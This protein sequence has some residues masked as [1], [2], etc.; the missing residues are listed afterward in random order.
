M[1]NARP[2]SANAALKSMA[3][4]LQMKFL[5]SA[6]VFGFCLHGATSA[7][8]DGH[9]E[10]AVHRQGSFSQ[11]AQHAERSKSRSFR[12]EELVVG[13]T[14]KDDSATP[15]LCPEDTHRR[16]GVCIDGVPVF[17]LKPSEGEQLHRLMDG[18]EGGA[19]LAE[20][21][22]QRLQQKAK[23]ACY[24][25]GKTILGGE[26]AGQ[27]S[28][29]AASVE[30]CQT[31][32]YARSE[33]KFFSF[34]TDG[35]GWCG[36]K[37]SDAEVGDDSAYVSGPRSCNSMKQEMW[38][39]VLNGF[40]K[41]TGEKAFGT[42]KDCHTF[43]GGLAEPA[44]CTMTG[45]P[46]EGGVPFVV[47]QASIMELE[48]I[49]KKQ[50]R[51]I[52]SI[53]RD[54]E[55]FATTHPDVPPPASQTKGL[56]RE[57]AVVRGNI[58]FAFEKTNLTTGEVVLLNEETRSAYNDSNVRAAL[59]SALS[60]AAGISP[61]TGLI[62]EL[63]EL[64]MS[65]G[66]KYIMMSYEIRPQLNASAR[67]MQN[68]LSS[69]NL[70]NMDSL[71]TRAL[72]DM[73]VLYGIEVLNSLS[74]ETNVSLVKDTPQDYQC[75]T[76]YAK[77]RASQLAANASND[78]DSN[79][80]INVLAN[81]SNGPKVEK[82][83]HLKRIDSR[84]NLE[85]GPARKPRQGGLGI[86]VYVIDTGI[87]FLHKEFQGH[88]VPTFETHNGYVR[89]C[90]LHHVDCAADSHGHGTAVASLIG[91][92]MYGV[93]TGAILHSAKAIGSGGVGNLSNVIKAI[94]WIMQHAQHPAVMSMSLT[95]EGRSNALD[96]ALKKAIGESN[97][98][99]IV[100]AGD[101]GQQSACNFA[102]AYVDEAITVAATS[103]EDRLPVFANSGG[104]VDM[105]A[106]GEEIEAADISDDTIGCRRFSSSG[107]SAALVAGTAA[108]ILSDNRGA[109][110]GQVER[111][112]LSD[113]TT[114]FNPPV[115]RML[116]IGKPGPGREAPGTLQTHNIP[117]YPYDVR[118]W[119]TEV[120]GHDMV[121]KS[122]QLQSPIDLPD[123]DRGL[124]KTFYRE[125]LQADWGPSSVE[126]LHTG[127]SI[128]MN[129]K[130]DM[131]NLTTVFG[132]ERTDYGVETLQF[133]LKSC[134]FHVAS[135]HELH[136]D[137]QAME[138]SCLHTREIKSRCGKEVS[139][140]L[141]IQP[142]M[143]RRG[144]GS[145]TRCHDK[146]G[147][148]HRYSSR[149]R[150]QC[151]TACLS[152][153]D[154]TVFE[155]GGG[156]GSACY[157]YSTCKRVRNRLPDFQYLTYERCEKE[158]SVTEH[159]MLS[160][161]FQVHEF[162]NP[163]LKNFIDEL[164]IKKSVPGKTAPVVRNGKVMFVS[165][166]KASPEGLD[167]KKF[168]Q[169][170]YS[171]RYY[172][173]KGS[174]TM[175]PCTEG[176][177]TYV[178]ADPLPMSQEQLDKMANAIDAG[179]ANFRPPQPLGDRCVTD[180]SGYCHN[181]PI[182]KFD[183]SKIERLS[184]IAAKPLNEVVQRYFLKGLPYN[185][186]KEA[187]RNR[188]KTSIEGTVATMFK[189]GKNDATVEVTL[190]VHESGRRRRAQ[191]PEGVLRNETNFTDRDDEDDD[192]A[193]R[194]ITGA[195]A[196]AGMSTGVLKKLRIT[197]AWPGA[198]KA[199][200]RLPQ[201]IDADNREA[202]GTNVEV[203]DDDAS[204]ADIDGPAKTR[205]GD[206]TDGDDEVDGTEVETVVV[207]TDQAGVEPRE[208]H[209]KLKNVEAVK[210]FLDKVVANIMKEVPALMKFD[211]S[212][213]GNTV[214]VFDDAT[215]VTQKKAAPPDPFSC[216][217]KRGMDVTDWS[218][219]KKKWCCEK[220]EMGCEAYKNELNAG[221]LARMAARK[222]KFGIDQEGDD[223]ELPL[224]AWTRDFGNHSCQCVGIA[225][226]SGTTSAS[227][228]FGTTKKLV[229]YPMDVGSSCHAWD[230][231][232]M[233]GACTEDD[234]DPSIGNG[235]CAQPWC[236]V[237]PCHCDL[238]SLPQKATYFPGVTF[239]GKQL[240]YSYATCG[241]NDYYGG[242]QLYAC[243]NQKT[244]AE[245]E[246]QEE[247]KW[248]FTQKQCLGAEQFKECQ[249]PATSYQ[250]NG[251]EECQC[252]GFRELPGTT[253]FLLGSEDVEYPASDGAICSAWDN[254]H[255][256]GGC[257]EEDSNKL[258]PGFGHGWC[259]A[260]WCFVDPC[261]CDFPW[262]ATSNSSYLPQA[263]FQG[264][265]MAL[266]YAT[267]ADDQSTPTSEQSR[268]I[269]RNL[270]T[271]K[272]CDRRGRGHCVWTPAGCVNKDSIELCRD[273]YV[274]MGWTTTTTTSA[275]ALLTGH[276]SC[277]CVGIIG[278]S[279]ETQAMLGK[280]IVSYP[281][282]VGSSCQAWDDGRFTG[283]CAN[284][285]DEPGQGNG[286]CQ[287]SWCYVNPCDCNLPMSP[288]K[289]NYFPNARY[290]GRPM[291]YSY[292]ACGEVD[293]YT[294]NQEWASWRQD[295]KKIKFPWISEGTSKCA[296]PVNATKLVSGENFVEFPNISVQECKAKCEGHP[297]CL[298]AEVPRF[299]FDRG[300]DGCI[301]LTKTSTVFDCDEPNYEVVSI[302]VSEAFG[303]KA[304]FVEA[305]RRTNSCPSGYAHFKDARE[306]AE[307]VKQF[308]PGF[309]E[310][311]NQVDDGE[312]PRGCVYKSTGNLLTANVNTA[313]K[314][315]PSSDV[316]LI[317][318]LTT[319]VVWNW[320]QN[321]NTGRG[322]STTETNHI[323][324]DGSDTEYAKYLG[325][326]ASQKEAGL[327]AAQS[328]K[329]P[330]QSLVWFRDEDNN[331]DKE[332]NRD[333]RKEVYG[334]L[335]TVS[336]LDVDTT[337][338]G[339][340]SAT[341]GD[342]LDA[343]VASL[344]DQRQTRDMHQKYVSEL[345]E[346]LNGGTQT[347]SVIAKAACATSLGEDDCYQANLGVPGGCKWLKDPSPGK[348]VT[349][350]VEQACA[351]PVDYQVFG[352]SQCRCVG[353]A[354]LNGL[355]ELGI[356]GNELRS[357]DYPGDVGSMCQSWDHNRY[358]GK[359]TENVQEPWCLQRWCYVDKCQCEV[360]NMDNAFQ[361]T[362]ESSHLMHQGRPVYKFKQTCMDFDNISMPV[363]DGQCMHQLYEDDCEALG[364]KCAW[365][366]QL[367][368][369]KAMQGECM[370]QWQ[371]TTT[372]TTTIRLGS[373]RC[374]CIGITN[375]PGMTMLDLNNRT[376][377]YSNDFGTWCRAWDDGKFPDAC[378]RPWQNPGFGKG[379]CAQKWCF[380][381][382]C[383]CD[384]DELP[385][386]SKYLP[387]HRYQ[388]RQLFYSYET[389]GGKDYWSKV[390][391]K[392]AC[393]KQ[394]NSAA[395]VSADNCVWSDSED[396]PRCMGK[397]QAE[398]CEVVTD[399]EVAGRVDC[400]CIGIQ[401]TGGSMGE[402][403]TKVNVAGREIPYPSDVGSYCRTWDAGKPPYCSR[404]RA[405]FP[406]PD[407]E[408]SCGERWCFVDPCKC[409][410]SM[411]PTKSKMFPQATFNG[412]PVFVSYA[413]C[414]GK[415][416]WDSPA[417]F[418]AQ[419]CGRQSTEEDCASVPDSPEM[420]LNCI[421]TGSECM[422][423]DLV[424]ICA[425]DAPAIKEEN[426]TENGAG[427]EA[428]PPIV[429]IPGPAVEAPEQ[430]VI[431]SKLVSGTTVKPTE[432]PMPNADVSK[433]IPAAA[434][435]EGPVQR[436][437][438][439]AAA[440]ETI[441][442]IAP[443]ALSATV[444]PHR[445]STV[446]L[447]DPPMAEKADTPPNHH[448]ARA[449]D[450]ED[451]LTAVADAG[452]STRL[453][454]S[455]EPQTSVDA[456]T[457]ETGKDAALE[458]GGVA[459]DVDLKASEADLQAATEQLAA[460]QAS[461][462]AADEAKKEVDNAVADDFQVN[463]AADASRVADVDAVAEAIKDGFA[464][465]GLDAADIVAMAE[466]AAK[467][468]G[469]ED[470]K[471]DGTDTA[472]Q[473]SDDAGD[474]KTSDATTN[475]EAAA[476]GDS[477]D[478][479]DDGDASSDSSQDE[480]AAS[481]KSPVMEVAS[482]TAEPSEKRAQ[483]DDSAPSYQEVAAKSV[484]QDRRAVCETL[485]CGPDNV[486]RT[487]EQGALRCRGENCDFNTDVRTCCSPKAT[488]FDF[489][490]CPPGFARVPQAYDVLCAADV[491]DEAVDKAACC[492]EVVLPKEESG[493]SWLSTLLVVVVIAAVAAIV[494]LLRRLK[495]ARPQEED[496][497]G[498]GQIFEDFEDVEDDNML[499]SGRR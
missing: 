166:F 351:H 338:D 414:G 339:V 479:A 495:E 127:S 37:T 447:I 5:S 469:K 205:P 306:C 31:Q 245:C 409:G 489:K 77:L 454:R 193:S 334:I 17:G 53:E 82:P 190:S 255:F 494:L 411:P 316:K 385:Q 341:Q 187:Q 261:K 446:D 81:I 21:D 146:V 463:S 95:A 57:I 281:M 46:S 169:T 292:T 396:P 44:K 350:E 386:E 102:P 288:V 311:A 247:C 107:A 408:D 343:P 282:D 220:K 45:A 331:N 443:V 213:G 263:S 240:Y 191:L 218:L 211:V 336:E 262:L 164:P 217:P 94:D 402:M 197:K 195:E 16:G 309:G 108:L 12:R 318:K 439:H 426:A 92:K 192:T 273:L 129:F 74:E 125:K 487:S 242:K 149:T 189:F 186:L 72:L 435:K 171:A 445:H 198:A 256:P 345:I 132:R 461:G 387:D 6:V 200:K 462:A 451:A 8:D 418:A 177:R 480:S 181:Q 291:F 421:W 473:H 56:A 270:N 244:E 376:V 369:P 467:N 226:L 325:K 342:A 365:T 476:A 423:L 26:V 79:I 294:D 407:E 224:P 298:Q 49:L 159:A 403:M 312:L 1:V 135:E 434:P 466:E 113:A 497:K 78:S 266:S 364:K 36:F 271:S 303:K 477:D 323:A 472:T 399:F 371:T 206:E 254:G 287:R 214:L 170:T 253:K 229:P 212:A 259:A 456:R 471:D 388:G 33:C 433:A 356:S 401:N 30:D 209:K 90:D 178:M 304:K 87:Q 370:H 150:Q 437:A 483:S 10:V 474:G 300:N 478:A 235:W 145:S 119:S 333:R 453:L 286:W 390:N 491:C 290:Q 111:L 134:E 156:A 243:V 47:V 225:G 397:K 175:P 18:G 106:P 219:S 140:Y 89:E 48:G 493:F 268:T 367:C 69:Q 354:H 324:D 22:K 80:S 130:A 236:Y 100:E 59:E 163:F 381:D 277:P 60:T 276:P 165:T 272:V 308:N 40:D 103:R 222:E 128:K 173:Y 392:K 109:S 432:F 346:K 284:E 23:A 120:F 400:R 248:S 66:D 295:Q 363:H 347:T 61:T 4:H 55:V 13:G 227:V 358:P 406:G 419:D 98:T 413:T 9:I 442:P 201:P 183:G 246:V 441:T 91:G 231:G 62:T 302:D 194:P 499:S 280:H 144:G 88:A 422:R 96:V 310:D 329:G 58:S 337:I 360:A 208:L 75:S 97:I 38:I 424:G 457:P 71:V 42:S 112:L 265:P 114:L 54:V 199:H 305:G 158:A 496:I 417:T 482:I 498:K 455:E 143:D 176:I 391:T 182:P 24:N 43:C 121:C 278:L 368:V 440:D 258:G 11:Q 353:I 154:C 425:L 50:A 470:P 362:E 68:I 188:V 448:L 52:R 420:G 335:D 450:E 67:T 412:K 307:A 126:L 374:P 389:C 252:I 19:S 179:G 221:N 359:C 216:K 415:Y 405:G 14:A 430:K 233:P 168:W 63:E 449:Q 32:C 357:I 327:I 160:F 41:K 28:S 85:D 35:S 458:Q 34:H 481:A 86:H 395:C 431:A 73:G 297:D 299:V 267:C 275:P 378:E 373:A 3:R 465:K 238:E 377:E 301:L 142:I 180:C 372:S 153:S 349:P 131:A 380:V 394:V 20:V 436:S 485:A 202:N 375:V 269:C 51:Y 203:M 207:L 174:L 70:N 330:F 157:L 355:T 223:D 29:F 210:L 84:L 122:G 64:E 379:F 348:C 326:A 162:E 151:A 274:G 161:L 313:P 429:S 321:K 230:N 361:L 93:A 139:G 452:E 490:S 239:Q 285:D 215:N 464:G 332:N 39:L 148:L 234:Q 279:G 123:C 319:D 101:A 283:S 344:L 232:R 15:L 105:V 83:W 416:T 138:M 117:L 136:E 76:P 398:V 352:H 340:D 228:P 293:N 366:G 488:C 104:C 468:S 251:K 459:A 249:N 237:D 25:R 410:I 428:P 204:L 427:V 486:R 172:S 65:N 296:M 7:A 133:K 185:V 383:E 196:A 2:R 438:E 99:T 315:K 250:V 167:M 393:R 320:Y 322:K 289:G 484:P 444:Q 147:V 118:K 264:R 460:A 137:R 260:R 475:S 155:H 404:S 110:P 384:L 141:M 115:G 116:F 184:P 257:T 314:G 317:C 27:V 152:R 328:A 124:N 382:P 241:G 492:Y